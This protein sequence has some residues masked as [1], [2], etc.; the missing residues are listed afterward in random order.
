MNEHDLFN[1]IGAMDDRQLAACETPASRRRLRPLGKILLVAA[2]IA[3]L[4]VSALAAPAIYNAITRVELHKNDHLLDTPDD[5][6]TADQLGG[7]ELFLQVDAKKDAPAVLEQA[8]IP[9]AILGEGAA[10]CFRYDDMFLYWRGEYRFEQYVLPQN[11]ETSFRAPIRSIQ[12]AAVRSETKDYL[13]LSVLEV[14][15]EEKFDGETALT[16][17]LYWSD[18]NYLYY[19]LLPSDADAAQILSTMTAFTDIESYRNEPVN[20]PDSPFL[21]P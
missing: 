2:V 4:S 20:K 3:A 17:Q 7:Y 13:G 11:S 5:T 10:Y 21:A 19:L 14:V 6:L 9:G 15:F 12:G 16:R 8:Y 1:A 18:G